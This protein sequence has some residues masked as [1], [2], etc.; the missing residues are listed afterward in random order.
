MNIIPPHPCSSLKR[1]VVFMIGC[2]LTAC[3]SALSPEIIGLRAASQIDEVI[4]T[5]GT[6]EDSVARRELD[7]IAGRVSRAIP[8]EK[9]LALEVLLIDSADRFAY[10][11]GGGFLLLSRGLIEHLETEAALAFVIAHEASHD[12]LG[13]TQQQPEEA[14]AIRT[15]LELAADR[16]ALGLVA[17]H[18]LS[19]PRRW[20]PVLRAPGDHQCAGPG[21][22]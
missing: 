16:Y 5:Y 4:S 18:E 6:I 13:H 10:A 8:G 22:E 21:S 17:G 3:T 2:V 20:R 11:P 7:E 19:D 14:Q 15:E 1:S 12:V 9:K